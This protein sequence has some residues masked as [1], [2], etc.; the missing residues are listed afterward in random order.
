MRGQKFGS[1]IANA[2]LNWPEASEK[3]E[4]KASNQG[5]GESGRRH[6]WVEQWVTVPSTERSVLGASTNLDSVALIGCISA[7]PTGALVSP[8][9]TAC[10]D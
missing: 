6:K 10:S 1:P 9:S 7:V 2:L 4:L 8:V 3:F 5:R